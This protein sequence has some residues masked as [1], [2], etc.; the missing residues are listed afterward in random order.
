MGLPLAETL[1]YNITIFFAVADELPLIPDP[2]LAPALVENPI[3][4]TELVEVSI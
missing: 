1:S 4:L 2:L 3:T